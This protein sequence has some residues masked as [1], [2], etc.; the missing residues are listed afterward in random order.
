MGLFNL[1]KA[2]TTP[3]LNAGEAK[4]GSG[5]SCIPYKDYVPEGGW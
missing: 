4:N 2:T 5:Y 3:K 1:N